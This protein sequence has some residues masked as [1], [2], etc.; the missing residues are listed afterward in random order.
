[1]LP[2]IEE[3]HDRFAEVIETFQPS[4]TETP[5]QL[6]ERQFQIQFHLGIAQFSLDCIRELRL[7]ESYTAQRDV[8]RRV[9]SS[10]VPKAAKVSNSVVETEV[11][12]SD[13]AIKRIISEH[14]RPELTDDDPQEIAKR[15]K[16]WRQ[17]K[18]KE[19]GRP[20]Y[21]FFRNDIMAE[22]ANMP[23][24]SID[25]LISCGMFR[26]TATEFGDEILAVIG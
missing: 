9:S 18:A 5:D 6:K 7:Q 26:K 24:Q 17:M 16:T 11:E 25:D 15:L 21:T 20:L 14:R 4:L 22:M 3:V 2:S 19:M 8:N 13:D 12:S 10:K 23:A 1:M